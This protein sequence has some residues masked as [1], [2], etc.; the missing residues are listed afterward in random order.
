MNPMVNIAVRAARS[1]GN[2]IA[3]HVDRL[4]RI[5]VESKGL[6]D[7]VS[8]V[9]RM[10]E[11]EIIQVLQKAYPDH[12]IVGEETG[13]HGEADY[14]WIIDPLDGTTNF[15]HGLPHFAVSIALQHKGRL[16]VGVIYD[17]MRQ[18][19]YSAER[20]G[21]A[22]LDGR[23]LRMRQQKSFSGRL[24]GTGFPFRQPQH[25]DAYMAMFRGVSKR[26]SDLRRAGSAAL[27][28]AYVAA[29]RLD[30]Y[31]DRGLQPWDLAAGALLVREAGGVVG[32][33]TGREGFMQSGNIVAG[34][35]KLFHDLMQEVQG[36]CTPDLLK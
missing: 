4:D 3:R 26:A 13:R 5:R 17:P 29:G 35:P 28:L 8:D 25:M 2:I 27:D 23:K 12:A 7:F 18:E 31:C 33:F 21:G 16:E 20:G 9:D 10:A 34:S 36:H 24:I 14:Q 32:D 1:A 6:N 11:Q 22:N 15:L 30:G 19:L